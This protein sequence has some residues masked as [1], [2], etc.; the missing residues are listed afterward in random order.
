VRSSQLLQTAGLPNPHAAPEPHPRNL[1]S[2]SG[3]LCPRPPETVDEGMCVMS[4]S[5]VRQV[6]VAAL[7]STG[8]CL[9][10]AAG[11]AAIAAAAS[12]PTPP[13]PALS[14]PLVAELTALRGTPVQLDALRLSAL[15]VGERLTVKFPLVGTLTMVLDGQTAG[16]RGEHYW[17]GRL[18]KR[19][20]DRIFIRQTANGFVAGLRLGARQYA[21]ASASTAGAA[22][23]ATTLPLPTSQAWRVTQS[24]G[25]MG[26]HTLDANLAQVAQ[27]ELGSEIALPLPGGQ[28]EVMVLTRHEVDADGILQIQGVSRMDGQAAPT[29]LSVSPAGVFGVV[30]RQGREYQIVTRQG[31]VQILDPQGAGWTPPRGDD[32]L[33]DQVA[34]GD[35]GALTQALMAGAEPAVAS[36]GTSSTAAVTASAGVSGTAVVSAASTTPLPLKAGTVDTPITVLMSYSQ[37]YVTVWGSEA[38]ARLR[39]SNLIQVANAAYANSGTGI[40][41][42]ITGWALVKQPDTTPQVALPALRAGTGNFSGLPALK[43]SSG[44][45]MTVFF[46]PFTTVTGST[47]TCGLAYVPASSAQGLTAYKAQAGSLMF[48]ALNDGQAGNYYC[49]SL[50]L[51]HELG[52]NLGNA[53]DKANSSFPGVFSYSYGKG[54]SGQFGTVMSYISPRV[55]LFSSPQLKCTT[56]GAACGTATENVVATLLQTKAT[57]AALGTPSKAS[58]LSEGF[59]NVAGWL[60]NAD[61]TPY[62]GVATLKASNAAVACTQGATGLYVCKVPNNVSSVSLTVTAT[63]KTVAPSV[64]SFSVSPLSNTPLNGTRFYL[65]NV[66]K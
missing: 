48:A 54:V 32:H 9:A 46:A 21:F 43:K 22:V 10:S 27:A 56:G 52:H 5:V 31:Q 6:S 14:A 51:A 25:Q 58:V 57:V 18:A 39:L 45:A 44:A 12:I 29:L 11:S 1:G 20:Q 50:T 63:G 35:P 26:V 36:A 17:H 40:A 13:A 59:T 8:A 33:A 38:L 41:F 60:L 62:T 3:A 24:P 34:L 7:L 55:A 28:T 66:K 47:N 15:Q 23:K 53:H 19:P 49:E 65:S 61:G 4:V 64:G 37:T 30:M 2:R 42:K 16:Q